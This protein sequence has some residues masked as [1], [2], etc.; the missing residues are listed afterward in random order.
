MK[1]QIVLVLIMAVAAG[2]TAC[3][4][5]PEVTI[6]KNK[7][8]DNL[9]NI[10]A[11]DSLSNEVQSEKPVTSP[12]I[13]ED[14]ISQSNEIEIREIWTD[15]ISWKNE[16]DDSEVTISID[17]EIVMPS[18]WSAPV[19]R[20]KEIPFTIDTAE[21]ARD[22][23]MK[24]KEIYVNSMVKTKYDYLD[25]MLRFK[26]AAE[27]IK[28]RTDL[29][30]EEKEKQARVFED[31]A[32]SIK[33]KIDYAPTEVELIPTEIQFEKINSG[34]SEIDLIR[35]LT[36][37]NEEKTNLSV[38]NSKGD[39]IYNLEWYIS[40]TQY[41]GQ[42]TPI[43]ISNTT[44]I[45]NQRKIIAE[46]ALAALDIDYMTA[47]EISAIDNVS[48]YL[49]DN[50]ISETFINDS[51]TVFHFTRS[52]KKVNSIYAYDM[53]GISSTD[54][55]YAP[56]YKAETIDIYV[57]KTGIVKFTW[58]SPME[59]IEV[60]NENVQTL[61][62]DEIKD[63]FLKQIFLS[64]SW[65]FPATKKIIHINSVKY[66]LTRISI[67]NQKDEYRYVPSWT[68][69]GH[70][71]TTK[72]MADGEKNTTTKIPFAAYLTINAIDGSIIDRKQGY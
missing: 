69:F 18:S 33:G 64:K 5:T 50:D 68:F 45:V 63:T 71:E 65:T 46:E 10:I 35:V 8:G 32:N 28:L 17:A 6:V 34:A 38:L 60:E 57:D 19:I 37:E 56:S 66:G 24:D 4:K 16:K 9:E 48:M 20:V 3:Q 22:F 55:S 26:Q 31:L 13:T 15:Q 52:Y 72:Y 53:E 27:N 59:I 40:G 42:E 61:P 41:Y 1:R 70:E 29:S 39:K 7:S 58:D 11:S 2:A 49:D 21:K 44:Q 36:Y 67:K 25:D 14:S 62:L 12:A 54:E 43:G 51:C 23:F 30:E 47:S